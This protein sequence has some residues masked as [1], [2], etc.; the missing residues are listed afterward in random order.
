MPLTC[1]PVL[2]LP[3]LIARGAATARG[4]GASHGGGS[5]TSAD[6]VGLAVDSAAL[7]AQADVA[8]TLVAEQVDVHVLGGELAVVDHTDD[9]VRAT[10]R[11]AELLAA[12]LTAIPVVAP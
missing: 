5:A 7:S 8:L 1:R 10:N 2:P 4:S 11:R 12:R 9:A 3:A 6:G